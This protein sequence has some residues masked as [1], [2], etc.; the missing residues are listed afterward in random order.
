MCLPDHRRFGGRFPSIS[1]VIADLAVDSQ[2]FPRSLTGLE[3]PSKCFPGH[4]HDLPTTGFPTRIQIQRA[5]S[6]HE[7]R[8]LKASKNPAQGCRGAATKTLGPA[9][10]AARALKER[11][12]PSTCSPTLFQSPAS[13]TAR[14]SGPFRQAAAL[15]VDLCA[16]GVVGCKA[17]HPASLTPSACYSHMKIARSEE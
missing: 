8:R 7:Y 9:H 13:S 3:R 1:P 5:A 15:R 2:P 17:L 6:D 16:P 10:R 12:R 4:S 11:R 14:H